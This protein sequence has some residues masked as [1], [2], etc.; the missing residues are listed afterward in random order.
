[1]VLKERE[2]A[3]KKKFVSQELAYKPP[4]VKLLTN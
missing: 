2:K 1:M 3:F 4:V